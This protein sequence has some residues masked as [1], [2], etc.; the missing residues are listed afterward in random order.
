MKQWWLALASTACVSEERGEPTRFVGEVA[1]GNALVFVVADPTL[2]TAYACDGTVS[3]AMFEWFGGMTARQQSL[4]S[5]TDSATLD[6]DLDTLTGTLTAGTARSF[7]LVPIEVGFG[8]YRGSKTD[9][10]DTYELGI[11]LLDDT[12]QNGAIGITTA[13]SAELTTIVSPRIVPG[14]TLVTLLNDVVIPVENTL[15]AFTR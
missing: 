3:P 14:Q 12:T 8:L 4:T 13:S 11:V 5:D 9:G 7:E 10:D 2:T 15:N 6:I 1:D